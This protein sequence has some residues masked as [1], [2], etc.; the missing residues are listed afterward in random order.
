M[1]PLR[2]SQIDRLERDGYADLARKIQELVDSHNELLGTHTVKEE[3]EEL[4]IICDS[5]MGDH[6]ED[7]AFRRGEEKPTTPEKKC[8]HPKFC[9][10]P[11]MRRND[12]TPLP[13]GKSWKDGLK[14]QKL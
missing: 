1:N 2:K 13:L 10:C 7:H 6:G 3:E 12:L 9:E 11:C 5:P 4:C 8:S 14:P